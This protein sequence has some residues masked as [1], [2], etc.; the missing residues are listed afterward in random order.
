M[1]ATIYIFILILISSCFAQDFSSVTA[2]QAKKMKA[3]NDSL[4][5][6]DVRTPEEYNGVLGHIEGA[7]L[8]P[9]DKLPGELN[10]LNDFKNREIIVYC[11]S[12]NRSKKGTRIL[13]KNGFNAINMLGGIKAW[14]KL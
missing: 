7:I 13:K 1:K 11:R 6:V 3:D 12:G 4:I 10:K 2:K 8:I 5:F 14:N 9:L